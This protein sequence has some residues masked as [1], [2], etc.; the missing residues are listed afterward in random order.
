VYDA[1]SLD[2]NEFRFSRR[3]GCAVCGE[4]P[5]ITSV[6]HHEEKALTRI[7]EWTARQLA[8]ELKKSEE[9]LL[10]VDV[11]E[12]WEWEEGR[13]PGSVHIP[14]G[15]LQQRMA[16]IPADVTPVFICA[17]G[18]RSMAAC[19]MFAAAENRNAINLD[20]GIRG[21]SAI[22][23]APPKPEQQGHAH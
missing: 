15:S 7:T 20:G 11:R 6:A 2:F 19:R 9:D 17:V 4:H 10:L 16:E 13:L 5:T 14:L 1:L 3:P 8:E 21:W 23:G 12:P 18:G 22:F